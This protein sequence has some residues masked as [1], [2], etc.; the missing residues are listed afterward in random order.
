MSD[1]FR[2]KMKFLL[3]TLMM[4]A[5]A[6][7]CSDDSTGPGG[8]DPPEE[9]V[10][11]LLASNQFSPSLDTIAV[12][13]TIEWRNTGGTAHTVTSLN[14]EWTSESVPADDSWTFS[15]MFDEVGAY[16]YVCDLH[17]NMTGRIVVE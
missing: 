3:V 10:V 5:I 16:D 4:G 2:G 11:E 7:A 12:N 8:N 17:A 14:D 15:H 13:T 1:L 9:N 6:V